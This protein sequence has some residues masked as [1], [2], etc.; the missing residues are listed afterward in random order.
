MKATNFIE[1]FLRKSQPVVAFVAVINTFGSVAAAIWLAVLGEWR[2][3]LMGLVFVLFSKWIISI[4]LLPNM[5]LGGLSVGLSSRASRIKRFFGDF[6]G[7]LSVLY[8]NLLMAGMSAL[9]FSYFVTWS[10]ETSVIGIFP[11]I[12]GS[13]VIAMAPW[14]ALAQDDQKAGGNDFSL[15]TVFFAQVGYILASIFF[16]L[17]LGGFIALLSFGVFALISFAVTAI[18]KKAISESYGFRI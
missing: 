13:Y 4:L 9:V 12:L 16:L 10:D 7:W 17:G 5:L 18:Y 6:S 15:L 1:S 14:V 11:Y 8:T 2:L 3:L